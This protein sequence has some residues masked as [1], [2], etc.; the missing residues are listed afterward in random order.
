MC[1]CYYVMV[2]AASLLPI[3]VNCYRSAEAKSG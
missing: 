2:A 1:I 3:S